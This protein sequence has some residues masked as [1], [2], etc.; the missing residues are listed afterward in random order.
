MPFLC[1]QRQW[2]QG[3]TQ[4]CPRWVLC[5]SCSSWGVQRCRWGVKVPRGL[6][7]WGQLSLD[8]Q[9]GPGGGKGAAAQGP[10]LRVRGAASSPGELVL[11]KAIQQTPQFEGF[12]LSFNLCIITQSTVLLGS[13]SLAIWKLQQRCKVKNQGFMVGFLKA[14]WISSEL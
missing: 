1:W 7:K 11:L 14:F 13:H 8:C 10:P 9:N 12:L 4:Y 2:P 3:D 6:Q 5:R